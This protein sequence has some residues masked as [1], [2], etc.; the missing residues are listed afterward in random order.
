LYLSF[1]LG[2]A[3]WKLT[4]TI[5]LG[6]KPRRREVEARNLH[7]VEWEI[8]QAKQRFGLPKQTQV[9]SCYEAGR[10]GFWLHRFLSSIAVQ[11]VVVDSASIQ[12][13]RRKRRAKTDRLDGEQLLRMLIRWHLGETHVWSVVHVPSP[14]EEDGRQLSRELEGLRQEQT[15]HVNRIK[16]L[17]CGCGLTV[18]VTRN[19][20]LEL[21][22]L[23]MWNAEPVPPELR[24]RLLREFERMQQLNRQIRHLE[25]QRAKRI[26]EHDQ[27]PQ[28]RMV[29]QLLELK[30]IGVNSSWL[31]V[32][33]VFG[34]RKIRNRRELASLVGLTPTPYN[35]GS[36]ER[37]QGI[38]KAGNRRVRVMA[39]EIAWGWLRFQPN[40]DL[41][42][43]YRRR[44]GR[45]SKR[46]RK[47]GIVA[48]ARKLLVAL[49]KYLQ[50]GIP[51]TGAVRGDWETKTRRYTLELTQAT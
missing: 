27:D 17:L 32:K 40:S 26:R 51:P 4:F 10:D 7:A 28:V 24:G 41:S 3:D 19:F 36:Q 22:R 35:S 15:A 50:T 34:W 45:G 46:Q 44:F 1:E 39:I 8:G 37:D 18:D 33:E 12:V 6:Q 5:G 49:W 21:K 23:R 16:G 14:E 25:K 42:R 9:V 29:R 13:D 47:I 43:W 48:L 30:G 11:N 2:E 38:S 20:P 31:Y